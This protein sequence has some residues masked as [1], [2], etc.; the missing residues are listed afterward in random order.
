M[1]V[2]KSYPEMSDKE[3]TVYLTPDQL[4]DYHFTENTEL[5]GEV[6][7]YARMVCWLLLTTDTQIR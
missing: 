2:V 7:G 5:Q 1:V 4:A 3:G 6:A